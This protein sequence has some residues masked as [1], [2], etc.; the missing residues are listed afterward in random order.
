M[1]QMNLFPKWKY[2]CSCREVIHVDTGRE[3]EGGPDW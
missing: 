2:R 3:E 1:V